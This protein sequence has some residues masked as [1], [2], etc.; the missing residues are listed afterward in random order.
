MGSWV[1]GV[2]VPSKDQI[3]GSHSTQARSAIVFLPYTRAG[4]SPCNLLSSSVGSQL[5][6]HFQSLLSG[7]KFHFLLVSDP[8]AVLIVRMDVKVTF[9]GRYHT[10]L[11]LVFHTAW[12]TVVPSFK[13]I[14]IPNDG[15]N[16]L[17]YV[18]WVNINLI[19]GIL[20]SSQLF[21][22]YA[23]TPKAQLLN[24]EHW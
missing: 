24:S 22:K 21:L 16:E 10:R 7:R 18:S 6:L 17:E 2:P 9:K 20:Y 3:A 11:H 1:C 12:G 13:F 4:A 15:Y 19:S 23:K 8:T 14:F 5:A